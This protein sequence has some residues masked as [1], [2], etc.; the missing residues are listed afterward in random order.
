VFLVQANTTNQQPEDAAAVSLN[1]EKSHAS[2]GGTCVNI[3]S[4][5]QIN[6]KASATIL[7]F[8]EIEKVSF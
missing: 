2:T 3:L 7:P 6:N 4:T 5:R 1:I 8:L